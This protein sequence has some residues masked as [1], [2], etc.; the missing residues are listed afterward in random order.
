MPN[1]MIIFKLV[2]FF[3]LAHA[4]LPSDEIR[5]Y[6]QFTYPVNPINVVTVSDMAIS[7]SLGGQ[8]IAWDAEKQI[9][10]ALVE[11][12]RILDDK[13]YRLTLRKNMRWSNAEPL[14]SIEV[15]KS[16]EYALKT[17]PDGSIGLSSVLEKIDC[18]TDIDIDFHLKTD[19]H[20]SGLLNKLVESAFAIYKLGDLNTLNL[21]IG[22][23]PYTLS[24]ESNSK[25]LILRKNGNW[26]RSDLVK[27]LLN[28]IIIRRSPKDLDERKILFSDSWPNLIEI[29]SAISPEQLHQFQKGGF[30]IWQRPVD[31]LFFFR[32]SSRSD[33][34]MAKT[35]L[36]QLRV[37]TKSTE[38]IKGLTGTEPAEQF[39]PRGYRLHDNSFSC[40]PNVSVGRL[41]TTK[42]IEI[43][44]SNRTPHELRDNIRHVISEATGKEPKFKL[45]TLDQYS[46][47]ILKGEFDLY[48][49][50]IGLGD[51][52]S[53]GIMSYY[54]EMNPSIIPTQD[55]DFMHRFALAR[56]ESSEERKYIILRKILDD[57]ICDGRILPL[58]YLSTL[59]IARGQLDLSQ[60]P[61]S[62][63][64]VTFAKVRLKAKR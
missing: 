55:T 54:L 33:R 53:E 61:S 9:S 45:T 6:M 10:A 34:A 56:S 2:F 27:D 50:I 29:S 14:T 32:I 59:G 36:K 5:T 60:I 57:A 25:E 48:A 39:F 23:G 41:S 62:D 37:G 19:A 35:L 40:P 11:K 15:K 63:E 43:G 31:R 21:T 17:H 16:I 64:S 52:D 18:P 58:F 12:W 8:L 3:A 49:G 20:K 24:N 26:Y 30:E 44:I 22:V 51:P 47:V 38:Y 7:N 1:T 42:Q 46:Q 28:K 13:T 4:E